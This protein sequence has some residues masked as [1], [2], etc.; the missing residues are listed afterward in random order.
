MTIQTALKE[1][2]VA[3]DALSEGETA[4]LLRK[5]GIRE[6]KG[7]FLAQAKSAILFPTFEHQKA[8]LLK[9][10]YQSK[11]VS[12]SSGWHPQTIELK[13]WAEI[14]EIFLTLDEEKVAALADFHIWQPQ[15]AQERLKWKP[16]QP[17]YVMALR[18]YLLSQPLSISWSDRYQGCRSWISL[19]EALTVDKKQPAISEADYSTLVGEI[20]ALLS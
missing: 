8:A 3:V 10:D 5:G 18:V 13:A 6:E 19:E 4:I 16:K 7:R 14:T 20:A 11:V 15:L 2:S 12:V 17:L 1:W 9:P